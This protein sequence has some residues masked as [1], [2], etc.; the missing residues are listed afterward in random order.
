VER[1]DRPPVGTFFVEQALAAGGALS[2]DERANHHARVKRIED[3]DTVRLVDGSGNVAHGRISP[4]KK[5][6]YDVAIERVE[7]VAAPVGVHLRVPIGDRDRMLW[8]AEKATELGVA[9]WQ[10][11]TYRRSRSVSPRGEGAAFHDKVRARMISALEQSGG[12]WLPRVLPDASIDDMDVPDDSMRVVL[13]RDGGSLLAL[14]ARSAVVVT[15]G[16][17]G[18]LEPDELRALT[19]GGWR[20]VRLADSTLRFETAGI[21]AMAVIRSAQIP[22]EAARG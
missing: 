6:Q 13:D 17:E 15:F 2:L 1:D 5:G 18:G 12:A 14:E 8:L 3:G 21:A 10:G 9:S 16:P 22:Q 19:D 11:V 7:T 20:A 4:L